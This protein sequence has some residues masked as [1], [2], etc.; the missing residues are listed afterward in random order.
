MAQAIEE[1]DKLIEN[2]E[3]LLKQLKSFWQVA[4]ECAEKGFVDIEAYIAG[5]KKKRNRL[6]R[7]E[8][9]Q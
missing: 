1:L 3:R 4:V 5:L 8:T 2:G 7:K 9:I 6:G